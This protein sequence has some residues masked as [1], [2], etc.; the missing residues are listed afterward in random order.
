MIGRLWVNK[1]QVCHWCVSSLLFMPNRCKVLALFIKWAS[2]AFL[3]ESRLL[4]MSSMGMRWTSL[5]EWPAW[6]KCNETSVVMLSCWWFRI[7]RR[8]SPKHSLSWHLVSPMYWRWHFLHSIRYMR[9]L[10]WQNMESVIFLASLVVKKVQ[11]VL[12][13]CRKEQ[14][15]Q[16]GW[17]HFSFNSCGL[18]AGGIFVWQCQMD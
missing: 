8:C 3:P 10:E 18:L 17:L 15:R 16:R 1:C 7:E 12:A 13:S 4:R 9:F 5:M 2:R 11:F 6:L 14:V